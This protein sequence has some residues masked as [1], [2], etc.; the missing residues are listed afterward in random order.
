MAK[1]TNILQPVYV[2]NSLFGRLTGFLRNS[3]VLLAI[4]IMVVLMVMIVPLPPIILDILITT[5]IALSIVIIMV[6]IYLSNPLDISVFPGLLLVM[7]LFRLSLNVASTRLILGDAYAGDVIMAFGNFVVKGNYV[8]GFIIFVVLIIIQFIVIVK[9]AGRIAEV[10][11]RFTLD[12]MPGKQM[13]ID[14]D[15]NAGIITEV[16]ARK[17]REQISREA[18]FYGAMDGA[19]K[20]VKGDAIAGLIIVGINIVGGF[21][22]GVLQGNMDILT[23]LKTY[24]LLTIGD[25]L[26]TQIPA[27]IISTSAGLVI[28]RSSSGDNLNAELKNQLLKNSKALYIS[29]GMLCVFGIVPGM[30]TL[31]FMLLSLI[32]A[33]LGYVASRQKIK[34]EQLELAPEKKPKEKEEPLESYLQVDP[35]ELEIGYGLIS[36]VDEEQGGDLFSR[37][38]NIRKQI[39]L[40]FGYLV[41]PI[42]I[43][44]NLQL[45]PSNYIIKIRG[46]ILAKGE[47]MMDK[48]LAINPGT[49]LEEVEGIQ[50]IDPAFGLSS[51]WINYEIKENAEYSGYT[52]VEPISVII[53]HLSEI[54]KANADKL[55]GKQET[56]NII[57]NLKKDYPA[58]V[59]DVNFEIIS[60][61]TIQKV[62][63]NLLKEMI[64]IRDMVTI[65][66]SL[67][68]YSK[69][70][71][72]IDVLT[73][74]VRHSLSETLGALY[75]DDN[76]TIYAIAVDTQIEQ[77]ITQ[78]LQAQNQS[79][80][81]LGLPPQILDRI[82]I[83][84]NKCIENSK[85]LGHKP[86]IITPATVR[87]Y[88]YRMIMNSFKGVAVLSFTELPTNLQIEF[89]DKIVVE[90]EA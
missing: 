73:E 50:T 62:L 6:A 18:E 15:L 14:A 67:S 47:L 76:E 87:L 38:A 25:G 54:I 48:L 21:V 23:A 85:V 86:V 9:G 68:D 31:S 17:R 32:F 45:E 19:S 34:E 63:Q 52:V 5:N 42:R 81:T 88:F 64:P 59:D 11:A 66:E 70:T 49:V 22:I 39:A 53:T 84:V 60:L 33:T 75:A 77:L 37:I 28:T 7:T 16:D 72:N 69:V 8:V 20:F 29:S 30:P 46:N 83:S 82:L 44:D 71:K 43:R 79:S 27:L 80:P 55:L 24:T 3:D 58:V 51:T 40:E 1:T 26:V 74:Y 12:A 41:P 36:L 35:L 89:I 4:A 61:S 56:K 10:A 2:D 90:H 65:L 57:D 78:A 13:S